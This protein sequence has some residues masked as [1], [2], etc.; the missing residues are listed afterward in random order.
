LDEPWELGDDGVDGYI[1]WVCQLRALAELAGRDMLMW[2]DVLA[3]HPELLEALPSEVTVCEWGYERSHPFEARTAALAAAG[4]R[5]WVCPGTSS[6][7]S[8]VGRWS[9]AR[10]NCL[11]ATESAVR[12]GGEGVLL[13]DWGDFGHLQYLPVSEPGLAYGAAVAWNLESNRD[14]D[15]GAALSTHAYDDTTGDLAGALLELGNLYG[16]VTPEIPNLSPLTIHLYFPTIRLGRGA[17]RGLTVAEVDD[18]AA[19][20]DAVALRLQRSRPRRNDGQLVT[21]E[22]DTAVDL[23]NVLARDARARL[24]GD[25]SLSSVPEALRKDLA[26]RMADIA[27]RHRE[28]WAARNRLGGLSD[29]VGWLH[30][31]RN[32]YVTGEV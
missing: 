12:R 16:R 7:L 15:I 14:I 3:A 29:S 27:G 32:A 18:V 4:I 20:L 22:L 21:D 9:N 8:I 2:G 17:T 10:A 25:G 6:W 31:L 19:T 23:M 5:F 24:S 28:L 13:T 11:A 30:R 1:A 26:A